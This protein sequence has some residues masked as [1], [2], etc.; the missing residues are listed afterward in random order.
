MS[1][2]DEQAVGHKGHKSHV[3][4]VFLK[5]PPKRKKCFWRVEHLLLPRIKNVQD[6]SLSS[7]ANDLE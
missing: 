5:V 2:K 6:I 7:L 4:H 3:K 1:D